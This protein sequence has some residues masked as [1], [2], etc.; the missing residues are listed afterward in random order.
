MP[1]VFDDRADPSSSKGHGRESPLD[2]R[3]A[4]IRIASEFR[5]KG[6]LITDAAEM[7]LP[8]RGREARWPSNEASAL[9]V[10]MSGSQ[11]KKN[12]GAARSSIRRSP[13]AARWDRRH[14]HS[15]QVNLGIVNN[16]RMRDRS[17]PFHETRTYE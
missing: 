17:R 13:R 4:K 9:K 7:R 2:R 14:T 5:G 15:R 1:V 12:R 16:I 6:E 11:E 8:D 10:R 3:G